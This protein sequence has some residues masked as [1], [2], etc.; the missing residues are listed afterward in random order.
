MFVCSVVMNNCLRKAPQTGAESQGSPDFHAWSFHWAPPPTKDFQIGSK[1]WD[2]FSCQQT[3]CPLLF[4]PCPARVMSLGEYVTMMENK[5]FS[6]C[7][8]QPVTGRGE[9]ILQTW[10][11]PHFLQRCRTSQVGNSLKWNLREGKKKRRKRD[12][13]EWQGESNCQNE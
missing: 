5:L 9:R 4:L 8:H 2:R 12:V 6:F 13:W 10:G 7:S 3:T 11:R 1:Q